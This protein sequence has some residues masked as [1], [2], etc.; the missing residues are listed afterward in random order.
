MNRSVAITETGVNFVAGTGWKTVTV[1]VAY[2]DG[3]A[4]A[5]SLAISTVLT[6]YT[7]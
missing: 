5:R 7:P 4:T 1:T 2:T 6:D 3:Q